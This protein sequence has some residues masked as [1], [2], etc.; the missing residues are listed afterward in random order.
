MIVITT[1]ALNPGELALPEKPYRLYQFL[2]ELEDILDHNH[3]T[4]DCLRIQAIVPLV[5]KLLTR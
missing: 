3:I 5:R 2:T 4:D 1:I